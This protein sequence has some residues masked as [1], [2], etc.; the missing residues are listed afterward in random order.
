MMIRLCKVTYL[1]FAVCLTSS[2]AVRTLSA[3]GSEVPAPLPPVTE[4]SE[5]D[6][7]VDCLPLDSSVLQLAAY[8]QPFSGLRFG[9]AAASRLS[10][11]IAPG[12]SQTSPTRLSNNFV[13]DP[14]FSEGILVVGE[15]AAL[16]IGG[17]VKADFIQDFNAIGSTD[18]FDTTTIFTDG[19]E[20]ENAR[21][22]ARQSRLSFDTRWLA[23]DRI[24]RT[25]IEADFF[26]DSN[27]DASVFR[28]RHAYGKLG[29][30]T[31]GQTWT[32]FTDPSAV[33]QT[34]DVEGAASNV[35]RRQALMR[36]D[37]PLIEDL[38]L[39]AF[40]FE[41]P[42][43]HIE[44]PTML[45]G[46]ARTD[47]PDFI[48]RLRL[49]PDWGEFQVAGLLRQLGFQPT[50]SSVI[51]DTAWG[52]NFTGSALLTSSTKSYYQITFGEGIGSYRGSPDVVAT[53]P[54]SG[55]ILPIFAWL[56]GLKHE[57]TDRL[58]SNFT[59]S[60]VALEDLPGQDPTNLKSTS[61]MAVNLI[62]N[63]Y[64]RVF[65]GVEYLYGIREDVSGASGNANRMQF[66]CGFFLP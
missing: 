8:Q 38:L 57:W 9:R 15:A 1:A 11:F 43:V 36:W 58:N 27:N 13:A 10:D 51:T 4:F 28:L 35:N 34:L 16:K 12:L 5:E 63:P 45:A 6:F 33:P 56:V 17:Y 7:E 44:T 23:D 25:F 42:N 53:G 66:S 32:T 55:E 65:W 64:E 14:E 48:A 19:T 37:Q 22:H 61:Y 46:D 29:R 54:T 52:F 39:L 30:V 60:I 62:H 50:G 20:F 18:S 24:V 26:G 31:A 41:D 21:F 40:A 47:T 2:V 59:F 3:L 49:E